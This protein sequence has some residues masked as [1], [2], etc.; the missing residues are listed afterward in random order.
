MDPSH[1]QPWQFAP[2]SAKDEGRLPGSKFYQTTIEWTI[3][4]MITDKMSI[5]RIY[6]L[7]ME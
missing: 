6:G 1:F 3:G 2:L 7:K 4:Y 5:A